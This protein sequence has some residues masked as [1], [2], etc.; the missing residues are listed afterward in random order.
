M[1]KTMVFAIMKVVQISYKL[2]GCLHY[3]RRKKWFEG[4]KCYNTTFS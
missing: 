4:S 1:I 3:K 2:I